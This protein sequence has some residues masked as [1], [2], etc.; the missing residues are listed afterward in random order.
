MNGVGLLTEMKAAPQLFKKG[1]RIDMNPLISASIMCAD[2]MNLE[3]HLRE[4]EQSGCDYIHVDIMDGAFVPNY[5][6]GT[7]LIR[8]LHQDTKIP[9]DIHL[10]VEKPEEKLDYFELF[11]QDVVSV[12]VEASRNIRS[13]TEKIRKKGAKV[14][15]ALNPATPLCYL[16]Y[17]YDDIDMILIMTVN[18]GYAGQEMIPAALNK[19]SELKKH[20]Q[21]TGREEI[22]I[23]VDGNVSFEN[24][25]KMARV[26]ADI[27]VAGSSSIYSKGSV[28]TDNV[29]RLRN[30]ILS[31]MDKN[32]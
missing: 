9:L 13:V 12:H 31:E 23:E 29:I 21:A 18:P 4:L 26:G 19:I 6:L 2:I 10:M 3:T 27:F 14:S 25:P 32:S 30:D 16:D 8:R 28:F 24:A 20:L 15:V 17:L 7:D 22:L 5:T 1:E 11:P